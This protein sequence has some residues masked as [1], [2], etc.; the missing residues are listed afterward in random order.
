MTDRLSALLHE[1]AERLHVPHA[2]AP[3]RRSP[4]G[5]RICAGAAG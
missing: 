4:R 1:E 5:R 3:A 2:D